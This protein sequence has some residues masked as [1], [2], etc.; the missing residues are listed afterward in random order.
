MGWVVEGERFTHGPGTPS[1]GALSRAIVLVRRASVR[2]WLT[3]IAHVLA[4]RC[5]HV[6]QDRAA[7]GLAWAAH[8]MSVVI[9]CAERLIEVHVSFEWQRTGEDRARRRPQRHDGRDRA[10]ENEAGRDEEGRHA[11]SFVALT[12]SDVGPGPRWCRLPVHSS[13]LMNHASSVPEESPLGS[14]FLMRPAQDVTVG[15]QV[16][17]RVL[18]G[19]PGTVI[20][21][22]NASFGRLDRAV[23]NRVKTVGSTVGLIVAGVVAGAMVTTASAANAADPSPSSSASASGAAAGS[24][25]DGFRGEAVTGSVLDKVKA[26]I[27]AKYPDAT[28]SDAHV[29]DDGTYKARVTKSDGTFVKVVL[30]AA[31]AVTE[32]QDGHLGGNHQDLSADQLAKVTQTVTGKYAGATVG[33]AHAASDGFEAHVTKSDGS[34]VEI[35][36]DSAYAITGESAHESRSG[37]RGRGAHTHAS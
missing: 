11:C 5:H 2:C 12:G 8:L 21:F 26:S 23:Q 13:V 34:Q 28:V 4:P 25:D 1:A 15:W 3:S 30:D 32:Q 29:H 33:R 35:T 14:L 20:P 36:L 10:D 19:S 17:H 37:H 31:F 7:G 16:T 6:R 9:L 18:P 27:V 24:A 22:P